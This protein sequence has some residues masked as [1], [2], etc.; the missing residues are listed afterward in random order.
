LN[1]SLD[2]AADSDRPRDGAPGPPHRSANVALAAAVLGFVVVTLDS[3]VVNV[4]LPDIHKDLG[5]GITGLQWV[6]DGYT[7]MFAALLLSAGSL[8]DRIG[9]HRA[10]ALGMTVFVLASAACGLAPDLAV[11]VASRLLQG[12][13]AA[14]MIPSSL[15]L[16][17]EAFPDPVRRSRALALWTIGGSVAA[18][19]GPVVGGALSLISWRVIFFINLPAG[20]VALLL[21]ARAHRSPRREVP[22]DVVGQIA[23][24]AAIGGLTYGIIEAGADGFASPKALSALALA[25]VAIVVF[26]A[27]QARGR[28]PMVPLDLLRTRTMVVSAVTGFAFIA[29]LSGAVFAYSLDLQQ[30]RGMSSFTAGLVFLPMTALSAFLG[31]PTARLAHA[32][33]PRVPIIGGMLL[34]ATSFVVLA[35]LPATVPAWVLAIVMIPVGINGPLAMQPTTAVLLSSVPAHRSG[36]RNVLLG[37][38]RRS[39]RRVAMWR[40]CVVIGG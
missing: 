33:G 36:Q 4:A 16:I 18:A 29:G 1:R 3:L 14:L 11:L 23:A 6:I 9:A 25:F 40:Q 2:Q 30:E 27:A 13:G 21:L 22:F 17:R 24:V 37:I 8:G 26:I 20:V 19:A 32:Y 34:M 12:A 38:V 7:L 31:M 39:F 28:H 35:A 5:G 15:S 10:F